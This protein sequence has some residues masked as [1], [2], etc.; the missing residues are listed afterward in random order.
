LGSSRPS[1]SVPVRFSQIR[2]QKLYA[3][4]GGS[5]LV[6][7]AMDDGKVV[8]LHTTMDGAYPFLDTAFNSWCRQKGIAADSCTFHDPANHLWFPMEEN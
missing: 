8:S 1:P 4:T 7:L 6:E 3:I 5:L 2:S